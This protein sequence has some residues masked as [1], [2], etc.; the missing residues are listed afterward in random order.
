MHCWL[1]EMIQAG[2][3][4]IVSQT[5]CEEK[6]IAFGKGHSL[7]Q[8]WQ[9]EFSYE[10]QGAI[11]MS[12][13]LTP[14]GFLHEAFHLR[15]YVGKNAPIGLQDLAYKIASSLNTTDPKSIGLVAYPFIEAQ[16]SYYAIKRMREL[17]P[18]GKA[19]TVPFFSLG[20][21][22]ALS[23]FKQN[24]QWM[25]GRITV[26]TEESQGPKF[27]V[28]Q[29]VFSDFFFSDKENYWTSPFGFYRFYCWDSERSR[30]LIPNTD[31]SIDFGIEIPNDG[32]SKIPP[33]KI[34]ECDSETKSANW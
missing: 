17:Y 23:Y 15:Q 30:W 3:L 33:L 8:A 27:R 31:G 9:K 28:M 26:I 18:K 1:R 13:C 34:A 32:W 25:H 22:E 10:L 7:L 4:L 16:A 29:K 5:V 19:K 2:N 11:L 14:H 6:A 21:H 24:F 12:S 20:E